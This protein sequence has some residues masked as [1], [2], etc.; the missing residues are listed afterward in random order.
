MHPLGMSDGSCPQHCV[1]EEL[2]PRLGEPP[3]Q[4]RRKYGTPKTR[5]P[6]LSTAQQC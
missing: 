4:H 1:L 2:R 5:H 3:V 6:S